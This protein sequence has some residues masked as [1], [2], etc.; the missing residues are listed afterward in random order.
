MKE[1]EQEI[2]DLREALNTGLQ[3]SDIKNVVP[4][5]IPVSFVE[6]GN[7]PGPYESLKNKEFVLTWVILHKTQTMVYVNFEREKEWNNKKI[8]WKEIAFKNLEKNSKKQL[9]THEKRREDNSIIFVAIMSDDGIGTS[10]LILEEK[11]KKAFPKGYKVALPE[12]S[13]GIVFSKVLSEDENKEVLTLVNNC[14]NSGT[15]P[16][17]NKIYLQNELQ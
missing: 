6:N 1:E 8:K 10:R 4:L 5:F 7:W 17:S 11:W 3:K 2:N 15:S 16:I 12:R 9:W 13:C 14:F